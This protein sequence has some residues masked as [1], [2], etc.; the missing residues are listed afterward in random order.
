MI[1]FLGLL[2]S[3][4]GMMGSVYGFGEK[5]CGDVGSPVACDSNAITA[6]GDAFDPEK[7]TVAIALPHYLIVRPT[8]IQIRVENGPCKFVRINDKKPIKWKDSKPWDLTP[9]TV[10]M[11]TGKPA[12]KH[13]SGRIFIC[14]DTIVI[15]KK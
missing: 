5:M 8:T 12:Q 2:F 4:S 7:A 15:G 6:S 11:L 14:F 1:E 3:Y 9:A 13:W 10:E